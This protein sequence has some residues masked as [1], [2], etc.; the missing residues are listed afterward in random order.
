ML[1]GHAHLYQR[2]SRSIDGH[3][4]PYIVSGS[5]G[6]AATRPR[7]G[8]VAPYVQGDITL[9]FGPLVNFGYL[10]LTVDMTNPDQ[11]H[12]TVNFNAQATNG[13]YT[14]VLG[15]NILRAKDDAPMEQNNNGAVG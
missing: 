13:A 5:G 9:A 12:L 7:E 14:M 2:F 15:P 10:L 1:S 11:K 6:F 3:E 4:I 8:I